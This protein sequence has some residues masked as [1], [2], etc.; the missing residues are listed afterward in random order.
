METPYGEIPERFVKDMSAQEMHDYLRKR[1]SRRRFLKTAVGA[2]ALAAAG[3]TFWQRAYADSSAAGSP[4]GPQWIALGPDPAR[5]M[6]VS[7]SVGAYRTAANVPAPAVRFGR[8]REY[9]SIVSASKRPRAHPDERAG[10]EPRPRHRTDAGSRRP[11]ALGST[12]P[13]ERG[14]LATPDGPY[15]PPHS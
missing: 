8:S 1:Y 4:T 11:A 3:P 6:H 12:L 14:V 2:G 7:W 10:S 15:R 5:E 13:R 9:G